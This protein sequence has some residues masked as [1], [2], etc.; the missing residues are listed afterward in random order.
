MR[1]TLGKEQ[2]TRSSIKKSFAGP[3][4]FANDM[5]CFSP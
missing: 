2:Q 4:E 5:D 3:I 1:R